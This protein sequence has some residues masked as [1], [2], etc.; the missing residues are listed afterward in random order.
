VLG[1]PNAKPSYCANEILTSFSFSPALPTEKSE[2]FRLKPLGRVWDCGLAEIFGRWW[3]APVSPFVF[4]SSPR[5]M[6]VRLAP[7][8][9]RLPSLAQ[10][11]RRNCSRLAIA[12]Y[13]SRTGLR[14]HRS[15]TYLLALP[16]S[17]CLVLR[18]IHGRPHWSP[19]SPSA[20]NGGNRVSKVCRD[21][22]VRQETLASKNGRTAKKARKMR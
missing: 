12:P 21:F 13:F 20:C 14:L 9:S 3:L 5:F 19:S 10:R 15:R 16:F 6:S 8:P 17:L 2:N 4:A 22:L 7:I 18:R 11:K 1:C